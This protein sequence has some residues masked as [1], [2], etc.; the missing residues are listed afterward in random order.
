MTPFLSIKDASTATGLSQ[1]WLREG[2]KDGTVPHV[3][4]GVKYM[5]NARQLLRQLGAEDETEGGA[6]DAGK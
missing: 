1:R 2:C 3:K 6:T 5:I 4:V